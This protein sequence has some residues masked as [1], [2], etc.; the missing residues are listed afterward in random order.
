ENDCFAT[1]FPQR[2]RNVQGTSHAKRLGSAQEKVNLSCVRFSLSTKFQAPTSR[3]I[4]NF[5][6]QTKRLLAFWS[7]LI[8]ASILE[9]GAFD[10]GDF[11]FAMEDRRLACQIRESSEP[12]DFRIN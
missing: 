4:P 1:L 6:I 8:G 10:V 11:R 9:F 12:P 7:L 2:P 3:E 5:N